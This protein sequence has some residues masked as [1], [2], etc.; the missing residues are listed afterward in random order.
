VKTRWS[1][2]QIWQNL[3]KE[4][5]AQKGYFVNDDDDDDDIMNT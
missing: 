2:R 1:D 3:I 4:A 5:M